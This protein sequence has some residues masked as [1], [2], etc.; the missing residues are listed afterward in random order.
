MVSKRRGLT[1]LL[2][3]GGGFAFRLRGK[4]SFL[5]NRHFFGLGSNCCSRF[6]LARDSELLVVLSI[7]L[8]E[9]LRVFDVDLQFELL[10]FRL[11]S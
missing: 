4:R 3:F 7:D 9:F 11:N 10:Q 2:N 6:F 8:G 5:A 1:D